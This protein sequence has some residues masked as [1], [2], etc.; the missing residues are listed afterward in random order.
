MN[1]KKY[2]KSIIVSLL[3]L[4]GCLRESE[5]R[6]LNREIN[7]TGGG[8]II[9]KIN[10]PCSMVTKSVTIDDNI[11]NIYLL[12]YNSANQLVLSGDNSPSTTL[13]AVLPKGTYHV[14]LL[15]N[16]SVSDISQFNTLEK[17][18]NSEAGSE[19]LS[20][21]KMIYSAVAEVV[22]NSAEVELNITLKRA[23]AKVT[24][25]FD[26]RGLNTDTHLNITKIELV[27]VPA[28]VKLF[29][30]NSPGLSGITPSGDLITDNLEPSSH[31]SA[32]PLYMFENLQG[33]SD[34]NQ[35]ASGKI[36][37][38]NSGSCTYAQIWA[39][40]TS[41][42]KSG[43]VKYRLYLGENPVNDF[44]VFRETHY[45]EN[46][47]F[48]GN[49]I[50]EISWRVDLSELTDV[51][52]L[53]ST[54]STPPEGGTVSGG[55][56]YNYGAM[57][58]LTASPFAG[59]T[60]TGWSPEIVPVVSNMSYTANFTQDE[61]AVAVTGI[62]LNTTSIKL[63]MGENY[64]AQAVISPENATNKR[65]IWSSSDESIATVNPV[66]G[67][68]TTTGTGYATI[69]AKSEDGGYS[70][71]YSVEV[72]QPLS[73]EVKTHEILEYDQTTG[74]ITNCVLIL[75]TRVILEVPS[76][77]SIVNA[78]SPFIT[79]N[80]NYSY[81]DKGSYKYGSTTLRLNTINNNDYPW[82]GV[83]GISEIFTFTSPATHEEIVET[84]NS[85]TF[86]VTPSE[87]Y[88]GSYHVR[89]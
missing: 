23:I 11:S 67:D 51:K 30:N 6:G 84:I 45:R 72:Y 8:K 78:I 47:Q 1:G 18:Y 19:V 35:G 54:S 60:F 58:A 69:T 64:T 55:G 43:K 27:N 33:I 17:L 57:P 59:F 87:K 86:S 71:S 15:A 85:F 31:E 77:M 41:P 38:V 4:A 24:F 26:K 9:L 2:T 62:A 34:N 46:I 3:V 61:P 80:V 5:N 44:N 81:I 75:Y 50:S 68:V 7:V 65:V 13:T 89:W 37:T 28:T 32:S 29:T 48:S 79:V 10:T 53:I 56:F 52:Y 66:S 74:K 22:L 39:D 20:G 42:Q 36:P 40:Y 14:A 82:N 76:D 83:E 12:I 73:L 63:D 70:S 21:G 49:A 25:V 16:Y 88:A